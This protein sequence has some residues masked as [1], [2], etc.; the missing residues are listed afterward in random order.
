M[1]LF[2]VGPKGRSL[3]IGAQILWAWKSRKYCK[4]AMGGL[5]AN[6]YNNIN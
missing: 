3:W 4:S 5:S 1:D 2:V 6:Q